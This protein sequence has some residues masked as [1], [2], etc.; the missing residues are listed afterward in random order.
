MLT[1]VSSIGGG[2]TGYAF[3]G[4]RAF[5]W[6]ARFEEPCCIG[7]DIDPIPCGGAEL[8]AGEGDLPGKRGSVR[9]RLRERGVRCESFG[10]L[11]CSF[12][13]TSRG[14]LGLIRSPE[15]MVMVGARLMAPKVLSGQ[16]ESIDELWKL[17]ASSGWLG[18]V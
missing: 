16:T 4:L 14:C 10:G 8:A 2:E 17:A 9:R 1:T 15:L 6:V 12:Y 13:R 3:L 18:E 11:G 5:S 7:E